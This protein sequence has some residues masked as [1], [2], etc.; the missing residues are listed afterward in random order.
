MIPNS[1]KNN[2]EEILPIKFINNLTR[3]T[4]S[5]DLN[6]KIDFIKYKYSLIE[7]F[8]SLNKT[9]Y[10]ATKEIDNLNVYLLP[11][12]QLYKTIKHSSEIVVFRYYTN[13]IDKEFLISSTD[14][15]IFIYE[16]LNE[17]NLILSINSKLNIHNFLLTFNPKCE[18]FL[19]YYVENCP[20][21]IFLLENGKTNKR[22]IN[23]KE[24]I[25]KYLLLWSNSL[26]EED[27]LILL[28]VRK[29]LIIN[30]LKDE[31]YSE[32]IFEQEAVHFHGYIYSKKAIDYLCFSSFNG[33]INIYDLFNKEIYKR[34][35][36]PNCKL[37]EI[38]QLT[39]NYIVSSDIC[40]S[41]F[42]IIDKEQGKIIS[43]YV[44]DKKDCIYN[45]KY[46]NVKNFGNCI[47]TCGTNKVIHLWKPS[48]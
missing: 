1:K 41:E 38:F 17:F 31:I 18:Y 14:N 28:C 42:V 23:I 13:S 16:P 20:N 8:K 25:C 22:T 39:D 5:R 44:H 7:I 48:I 37:I 30:M 10:L 47:L 2:Y 27:Y 46:I 26:N 43:S 36:C 24:S 45:I 3:F 35:E 32:N 33:Y 29:V 19:I 6:N 4:Y 21:S 9:S 12:N 40:F 11:N 15:N 34:I